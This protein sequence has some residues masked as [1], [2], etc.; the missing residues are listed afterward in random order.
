[1]ACSGNKR[2]HP[3][4]R[5]PVSDG[6]RGGAIVASWALSRQKSLCGGAQVIERVVCITVSIEGVERVAVV[7]V[8]R[9]SQLDPLG[10]IR[11]R[12]EIAP[13]RYQI[14][15]TLRDDRLGPIL[16]S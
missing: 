12:D 10:Q 16:P 6:F 5:A 7:I 14:S 3:P 1:M 4:T 9:Q 8:E 13:K 15:I 11:I 2:S